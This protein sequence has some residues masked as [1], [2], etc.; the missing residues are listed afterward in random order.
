VSDT[1]LGMSNSKITQLFKP[2]V[3]VHGDHPLQAGGTGLGLA[4]TKRIVN[5]MEGTIS[6]VSEP[7]HGTTFTVTLPLNRPEPGDFRALEHIALIGLARDEQEQLSASLA[8]RGCAVHTLDAIPIEEDNHQVLVMS[9]DVLQ[10]SPT[11][12]IAQYLAQGRHVL[13]SAPAT[14]P[15]DLP[16]AL[17]GDLSIVTGPLSPIRLLNA[18]TARPRRHNSTAAHRLQGIRVLAAED[19]PVNRLVLGQM[20]EQEGAIVTFAYDGAHALEQVRVHGAAS[21]DIM[22]CD[23]QMPILDG[24]Q[25]AQALGH[26]APTLPIIGLTAHAFDSAKQQAKSVGMVGYVTK[27]YMLDTL[28]EEIRRYSRRR[29]I[30][31]SLVAERAAA[32]AAPQPQTT[33][34]HMKQDITDWQAMQQYFREQPQL[35]D[36][37][38]GMLTNTL[39]SIQEELVHAT[40]TQN[41]DALAKVAHNIK[42]TALNLHT[43]EL[44][45]L[46]VQTQEQARQMAHEALQTAETL[47]S[48]LQAFIAKAVEHQQRPSQPSDQ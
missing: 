6:V 21:F 44:A 22:L 7:G 31:P 34:S 11:S 10:R 29:P 20:L 42:G 16:P 28:V 14:P 41:L 48:R 47:S 27:P 5:M 25:T 15:V 2:F 13:I 33:E 17:Q 26:I 36:R 30:D 8:G 23:I 45:R 3:Q 1:G 39:S 43:P 4:I 40:Q 38:I 32:P 35:L 18:L 12:V 46:A 19:N 9:P 37:L 24:Y